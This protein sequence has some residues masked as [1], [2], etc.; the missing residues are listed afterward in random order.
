MAR[1][2]TMDNLPDEQGFDGGLDSFD[3]G[4]GSGGSTGPFPSADGDLDAALRGI[5]ANDPGAGPGGGG[6]VGNTER[7][8]DVFPGS[9]PRAP[10]G[11][12]QDNGAARAPDMIGN[13]DRPADVFADNAPRS[14]FAPEPGNNIDLSLL[15]QGVEAPA[16]S[17][18]ASPQ[19]TAMAPMAPSPVSAQGMPPASPGSV[20]PTTPARQ[21]F[22][23]PSAIFSAQGPRSVGGRN[24]GLTG[25]GLSMP[26]GPSGGPKPTEEMLQLLRALNISG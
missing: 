9:N 2:R 8:A 7:P 23:S 10:V 21:P 17:V 15:P 13:R 22:S 6:F 26:G 11:V 24:A 3:F 16:Q 5:F 12:E 25:G 1:R 20:A 14:P 4:G 19:S 18:E